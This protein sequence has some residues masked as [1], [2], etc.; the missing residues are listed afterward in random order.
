LKWGRIWR[1]QNSTSRLRCCRLQLEGNYQR[2]SCL[3][4]SVQRC[5][6]SLAHNQGRTPSTKTNKGE[7]AFSACV[8]C[9][10]RG[11][12]ACLRKRLTLPLFHLFPC[13]VC[14]AVCVFECCVHVPKLIFWFGCAQK[15]RPSLFFE[16]KGLSTC[17]LVGYV[18]SPTSPKLRNCDQFYCRW[19]GS[20]AMTQ[21]SGV[22]P[23]L[24]QCL[25]VRRSFA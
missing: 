5:P 8:R 4:W 6:A 15:K 24:S 9:P 12:G 14:P 13:R 11:F 7:T 25:A 17:H 21:R 23:F 19:R 20:G 3:G 22:R 10:L 18:T 2:V 16:L 1:T